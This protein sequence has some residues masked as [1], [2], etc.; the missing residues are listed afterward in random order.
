[1]DYERL[2]HELSKIGDDFKPISVCI[3]WKDF[4]LGAHIP[5]INFGMK[6]VSAG[7]IYDSDFLFRIFHLCSLHQYAAGN[8]LGSHIFYSVKS[9]CSYFHFPLI[10]YKL[11][12]DE[13][14]IERDAGTAPIMREK[15]ILNLFQYPN[16]KGL[17]EQQ[18]LVDYYLGMDFFKSKNELFEELQKVEIMDKVR[19]F[20]YYSG[21]YPKLL[22]PTWWRRLIIKCWRNL[23]QL[24]GDIRKILFRILELIKP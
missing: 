22:I 1:M 8:G 19:F 13:G 11:S 18:R 23:L 9:G 2:A 5:F 4:N 15:E 3:Y 7:H 21:Y 14:V 10:D 6:V 12:A 16:Q 17:I 24:P 20:T